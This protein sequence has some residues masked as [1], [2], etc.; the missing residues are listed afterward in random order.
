[1]GTTDVLVVSVPSTGGWTVAVGELVA[2]LER[3]GARVATVAVASVPE[4]RT[5]ALTDYV[6]ARAAR[7]ACAHALAV[8]D[9]AAIVYCSMTAALLWPRPGAIWLDAIAAENRPGRHGIWQRQ[10]E[11]RRL[12]EAPVVMTMSSRAL[13][14]AAEYA[15]A[16]AVVPTPVASSGPPRPRDIAAVT[17]GANPEK[18]RLDFVLEAWERARRGDEELVVAGI[19]GVAP[20]PGVTVAGRLPAAEYR[21][22]LRRARVFLAAPT[23]EDYGIAPAGSAGRRVHAREHARSGRLPRARPRA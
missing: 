19:D 2:A 8:D 20:R 6:Q 22:L 23:R 14:G 13:E 16:V 12:A 21:A 1:M 9:P 4:V 11:R 10:V 17:Y 7:R 18:K 5:F 15:G 3:V